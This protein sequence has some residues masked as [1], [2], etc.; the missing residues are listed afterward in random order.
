MTL[1]DWHA[2]RISTT[3][4]QRWRAFSP[5]AIR[6]R[7]SL[8]IPLLLLAGAILIA[9]GALF[10]GIFAPPLVNHRRTTTT[11]LPFRPQWINI[12][13]PRVS[14]RFEDFGKNN[15]GFQSMALARRS[16]I[17]YV[18][19]CYQGLWKSSDRG[20]TWNK[21]N[22]G[23]NGKIL[24][25]GRLWTL[26]IDPIKT[27]VLYTTPGYGSEPGVWKSIDGG[28]N[29]RDLIPPGSWLRNTVKSG[30]I[31]SI[32]VDP[33]N[34]DHIL[35]AFH[36][37]FSGPYAGNAPLIESR[38]GGR[39]WTI[40]PLPN[41]GYGHYVFF[42]GSSSTWLLGTQSNGFWRSVDSGRNW[43]QVSTEDLSHG[44][45]SLYR[46]KTG[47]WYTAAWGKVLRSADEGATWTIAVHL[48]D[49]LYSVIGDG[50]NLYTQSANTGSNTTGP[51]PYYT[52]AETDGLHW[53]PYN[54][55]TFRDG[56][57]SMVYDARHHTLYSSNWNAGVWKIRL[58]RKA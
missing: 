9:I 46:A 2:S 18:G 39:T 8:P 54:S 19:T 29:W 53:A 57:M 42:M 10:S 27:N 16:G 31:Y 58:R 32:A 34:H 55:Q 44:A 24:D 17:V 52:S 7:R 4:F 30:D 36:S 20:R 56:P 11:Q 25:S 15:Y 28:R 49:Y 33:Y 21:V 51:Q 23:R 43:V 6:D 41:L 3:I 37:V 38:N 40:H 50:T 22:T 26:A 14:T 12:S 48:G 35:G 45:G 13:P 5:D 47:I 1:T